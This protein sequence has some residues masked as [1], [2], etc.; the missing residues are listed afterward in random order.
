[1][2]WDR[3]TL[4]VKTARSL[5]EAGVERIGMV[6]TMRAIQ[7]KICIKGQE[8]LWKKQELRVHSN[9]VVMDTALTRKIVHVYW[10]CIK[11]KSKI[12]TKLYGAGTETM[13]STI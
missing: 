11:G 6:K 4:G 5:K 9:P 2:D 13:L 7:E 3:G 1:M 10:G 8:L 12:L